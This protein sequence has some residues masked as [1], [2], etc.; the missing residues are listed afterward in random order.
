MPASPGVGVAT[1]A[2]MGYGG[3]LLGPPA[4]GFLA[5]AIGLR[6]AL[7]VLVVSGIAVTVLGARRHPG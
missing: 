2:T 5:S 4:I 3:F 7:S 6:A 1:V